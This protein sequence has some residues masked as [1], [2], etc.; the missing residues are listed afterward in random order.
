MARIIQN[1]GIAAERPGAARRAGSAGGALVALLGLALA[2]GA[3]PRLVAG[4]VQIGGDPGVAAIERNLPTQPDLLD[5]AIASRQAALGWY[6]AP[7]YHDQ[8]G[9]A[10]V[11]SVLRLAALSVKAPDAEKR[12]RRLAIASFRQ[13]LAGQPAEPYAWQQLALMDLMESGPSRRV[14]RFL[15]LS[16][17]AGPQEPNLV[18]QRIAVA[19]MAWTYLDLETRLMFAGQIHGAA[20]YL[21]R[22][23]ADMALRFGTGDFVK[24]V[25]A[26]R[27][28]LKAK[29]EEMYFEPEE[30]SPLFR[31]PAPQAAE[32]PKS[33][34]AGTPVR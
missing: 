5:A 24:T 7:Q 6:A 10:A 30:G 17:R 28:D 29:F 25:L 31:E 18:V 23:L 20:A 15:N 26:D 9:F 12:A 4:L 19:M 22:S 27:P 11:R 16:V 33:P 8:I 2:V 32:P 21:T 1:R 34:R 13:G 14:G 3:A